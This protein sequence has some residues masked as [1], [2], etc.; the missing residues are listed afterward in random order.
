MGRLRKLTTTIGHVEVREIFWTDKID[1][2]PFRMLET[3]RPARKA[4]PLCERWPT[5]AV[6]GVSFATALRVNDGGIVSMDATHPA[7]VLPKKRRR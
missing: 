7:W 1:G 4:N 3:D 2:G 5:V 6:E